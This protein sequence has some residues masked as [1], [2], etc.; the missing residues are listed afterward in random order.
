MSRGPVVP[1]PPTKG[2]GV[3]MVMP[4]SCGMWG[5]QWGHGLVPIASKTVQL[6]EECQVINAPSLLLV[7]QVLL[8]RNK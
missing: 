8:I 2:E 7:L 5:G 3:V 6:S 1:L 4:P